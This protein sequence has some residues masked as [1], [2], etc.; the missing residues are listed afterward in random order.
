MMPHKTPPPGAPAISGRRLAAWLTGVSVFACLAAFYAAEAVVAVCCTYPG[1]A[2]QVMTERARDPAVY[3]AVTPQVILTESRLQGL[4]TAG[5]RVVP[6]GGVAHAPTVFC[7]E[8]GGFLSYASDRYGFHNDDAMWDAETLDLAVVGDSFAQGACVPSGANI[9]A[10]LATTHP[11]TINLGS[12][13]N[14]PLGDLATL[15]EY[16]VP[17]K[18][19]TVLWFYVSNDLGVD[20]GIERGS[21]ILRRYLLP[22]YRQGLPERQ[23]EVDAALRPFLDRRLEAELADEPSFARRLLA[24][25]TGTDLR[26]ALKVDLDDRLR[27]PPKAEPALA[28]YDRVTSLDWRLYEQVMKAARDTVAGWGGK[29]YVVVIPDAR[30][31]GGYAPRGTGLE[32]GAYVG[33]LTGRLTRLGIESIDLHAAFAAAPQPLTYYVPMGGYYGHFN[34]AGYRFAAEALAAQLARRRALATS[35]P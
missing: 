34:E 27:P 29:L 2:R 11:A 24:H 20:L 28:D 18:P 6:L 8:G 3:P 12:F 7:R 32:P 10:L 17:K 15:K 35:R 4:D 26:H 19:R 23:A 31:Y 21:D 33:Q 5:G 13:G 1:K 14:G 9:P 25:L 22:G 30:M 16:L